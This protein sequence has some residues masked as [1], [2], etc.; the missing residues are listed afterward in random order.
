MDEAQIWAQE[1]FGH[2]ELGDLRRTHRLVQ[3]AAD[4]IKRPSG[5]VSR[6]CV[7]SASREGAFRLLENPCVRAESILEAICE[8]TAKDCYAKGTVIV[9]VDATSL[10]LEDD[11]S[12]G[13]GR[14]AHGRAHSRGLHAVTAL[15]LTNEGAAIGIGAQA[16]YVRQPTKKT[17]GHGNEGKHWLDV[18]ESCETRLEGSGARPWFQMDRGFDS[19]NVL[20][21]AAKRGSLITV[22]SR[23]NRRLDT[24][25]YLWTT[26][27]RAPIRAT[28]TI[29]VAAGTS[30]MA[31]RHR[32]AGKITWTFGPPRRA[33]VAKVV[34]RAARVG[35]TWTPTQNKPQPFMEINAV[36]VRERGRSANDRIEWVLLTTHPIRTRADVL[37]V[38]RAYSLRWRIEDFHRAWK[39]GFC[40]VEDTQLRSR[41]AIFKWSTILA[42]VATR[43][44]RLTHLA[45]ETP[46][47]LASTEFSDYELEAIFVQRQPK[48]FEKSDIPKM[49]L[50]QAIRWIADTAGYNG[51]WKGPPGVTIVGR[52]L[53]EIEVIAKAFEQRDRETA[54]KK[55]R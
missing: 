36:L 23:T 50:A 19:N 54:R 41:A 17:G 8:K 39:D 52:G 53:Y 35:L 21:L 26:L 34:I 5:I 4:V 46:N 11:G 12:K 1:Q 15:A 47:V 16:L 31:K 9:P 25:A 27:E 48:D 32:V 37:S 55:M 2:S 10:S 18:I 44:M 33:R 49:T 51:P 45:R 14:I 30:P 29:D 6:V 28:K 13:L 24:D 7:T 22:R 43:A 3:L 40:R 42:A 38:V 20:A